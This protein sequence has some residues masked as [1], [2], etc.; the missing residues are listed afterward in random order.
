MS[1]YYWVDDLRLSLAKSS[2]LRNHGRFSGVRHRLQTGIIPPAEAV[3]FFPLATVD[4]NKP[5]SQG[6]ATEV[7]DTLLVELPPHH[8]LTDLCQTNGATDPEF[9]AEVESGPAPGPYYTSKGAAFRLNRASRRI[10][11]VP[12]EGIRCAVRSFGIGPD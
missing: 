1:I 8:F 2:F 9:L 5:T 10:E 4:A 6:V 7:V 3:S 11:R 12:A